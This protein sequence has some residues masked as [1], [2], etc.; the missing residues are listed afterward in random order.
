[1]KAI[2]YTQYGPPEVLAYTDVA[3]P[4]PKDHQVLVKLH[5]VSLNAS[6]WE[7]LTGKPLYARMGGLRKSR[8][9]ILGSD[10]AGTVEAAAPASRVS[11]RA[12]RCL[13]ISCG[14]LGG[15]AEYACAPERALALKPSGLTFDQAAAIPQGAVIALQGMRD[16]GKGP[17]GAGGP[18]QRRG[19]CAVRSPCSW[20]K[21][22]G[23]R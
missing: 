12:T 17:A 14:P 3:K 22:T 2:V 21:C 13:A 5:A 16:K 9:H 20:P 8:T 11:S 7:G 18:D 1:M 19:R 15:L 6:D 4:V 10:I 23:R